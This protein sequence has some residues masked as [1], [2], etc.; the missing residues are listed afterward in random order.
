MP[1]IRVAVAIIYNDQGEVLIQ[2]RAAGTHQGGLWEFPG[3]KV[4]PDETLEQALLREIRE[5]LG[6]EIIRF[7]P[8]ITIAHDYGDRH[9]CLEVYKVNE[10]QGLPEAMEKQP[11]EWIKPAR[12]HELQMPAADK[13]IHTAIRL[14]SSYV[15]TPSNISDPEHILEQLESL[16]ASGEK[17]FL[18]RVKSLASG[19]HESLQQAMLELCNKHYA[20]FVIHEKNVTSIK[21]DGLHLTE[22]GL[23]DFDINADRNPNQLLS[24]SCHS[25]ESLKQAQAVKADFAMLSPVE[26]TRSHPDTEPLGWD[27]FAQAVA[28]SNIPVYALGGMTTDH[29]NKAW[30]HGAQGV[31]GISSWWSS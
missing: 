30:S 22:E 12:L 9:V 20:T 25:L 2:Q 31:A 24:A 23:H 28:C 7:R 16:L 10:W 26:K 5:E 11:L 15:I 8:L 19:S 17:L 4:E 6:L 3:G 18:Y 14:P 29:I 21:A 13:P 1:M 27:V